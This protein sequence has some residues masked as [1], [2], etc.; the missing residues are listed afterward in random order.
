MTASRQH[1]GRATIAPKAEATEA[2]DTLL[3]TVGNW[4]RTQKKF[5]GGALVV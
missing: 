5:V 1:N 2:S 3:P 4:L